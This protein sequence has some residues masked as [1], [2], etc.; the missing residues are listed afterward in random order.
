M[1][2]S[3]GLLEVKGLASAIMVADVMA[4]VAVVELVEIEKAKGFGWMTVKVVGDVAAVQASVDAGAAKAKESGSFVAVKVIPRPDQMVIETFLSTLKSGEI[5]KSEPEK[6]VEEKAD[7]VKETAEP[8][9]EDI[10][11]KIEVPKVEVEE[12]RDEAKALPVK[13]VEEKKV[14]P[15]AV[16]A[17][18]VKLEGGNKK[19]NGRNQKK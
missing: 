6:K 13:T 17:P 16:K 3:L 2:K 4:K 14:S 18:P 5:K 11:E 15:P 8:Q 1:K 19:N 10:V 9:K 12:K 7:S